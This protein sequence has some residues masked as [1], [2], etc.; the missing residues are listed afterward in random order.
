MLILLQL[1][2]R[3]VCCWGL[4]R[5][6]FMDFFFLCGATVPSGPW[7]PHYQ[8]FTITLRHTTLGR[9][10]LDEWSAHRTDL[11]PT[12]YSTHKGHIHALGGIRNLNS[13][14]QAVVGPRIKPARPLEYTKI[15]PY[16]RPRSVRPRNYQ[17]PTTVVILCH[18]AL[19]VSYPN[20]VIQFL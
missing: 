15:I 4:R 16:N 14:K 12:T 18:F 2:S 19:D 20:Q 6:S 13:S 9:T 17:I 3:K 5:N 8:G 10:T 1:S 11:D 7:P